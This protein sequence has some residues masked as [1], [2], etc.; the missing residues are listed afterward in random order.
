MLCGACRE[1][2]EV[3]LMRSLPIHRSLPRFIVALTVLDVTSHR[4]AVNRAPRAVH[5]GHDVRKQLDGEAERR[6]RV[7]VHVEEAVAR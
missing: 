4:I 7:L 5:L 3:L 1:P 6:A 2:L